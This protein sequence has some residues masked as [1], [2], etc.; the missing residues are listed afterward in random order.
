VQ[1]SLDGRT[2][3]HRA[4]RHIGKIGLPTQAK[5]LPS[6]LEVNNAASAVL[7]HTRNGKNLDWLA[8]HYPG[9]IQLLENEGRVNARSSLQKYIAR[10]GKIQSTTDF[11]AIVLAKADLCR[12]VPVEPMGIGRR[13][14]PG[15]VFHA[16]FLGGLV[17]PMRII[18]KRPCQHDQIN[19]TIAHQPVRLLRCADVP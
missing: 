5:A 16:E 3:K 9:S 4:S 17:G 18:K 19:R 2:R 8:S 6:K 13:K 10:C 1:S 15:R 7:H 12:S 11:R 14:H